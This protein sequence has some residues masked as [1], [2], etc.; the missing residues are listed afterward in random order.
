MK[1]LLI[2]IFLSVPVAS[3]AASEGHALDWAGLGWRVLVFVIFIA[4]MYKILKKPLINAFVKRT[5]DIEKALNEAVRAKEAAIAQMKEYEAKMAELEE[6]LA[7]MKA[8]SLKIAEQEREKMIADAEQSVAK[9]KQLAINMIEAETAKAKADLRKEIA[10][11]AASEAEKRIVKEL[12][13][14]KSK[15]ILNEYIKRIGA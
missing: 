9:M 2:A 12:D 11:V 6:E 10:L 13:G 4:L 14:K 3:F 1:K 8:N 5:A 7:V 15:D